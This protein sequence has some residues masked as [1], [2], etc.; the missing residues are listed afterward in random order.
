MPGMSADKQVTHHTSSAPRTHAVFLDALG[1][2]VELE[3]PWPHLAAAL[4]IEPD[5]AVV[6]AM[7]AEMAY[8]RRHSHEGR[9]AES[10]A[11]LR[12]RCAEVL[13]RELGR[14]VPVA[15][16]MTAIRFRAFPDALSALTALRARGLALVCVSNWDVSLPGVL[17]RCGLAGALD[18][19]VTSAEA[20]VRKPDP[21]IFAQALALARC[22]PGEALHVGDSPEEDVAAAEAAGIRAL[23]LDREGHGDVSSLGD[24]GAF[25]RA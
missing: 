22:E 20:G 8:Y 5:E 19:V 10:L 14:Q 1:T 16:M 17:E 23:L 9:D 13:S 18:G 12:E 7:R 4:G 2:L 24:V 6:R 3:P 15:T 11:A 25:V 21:A